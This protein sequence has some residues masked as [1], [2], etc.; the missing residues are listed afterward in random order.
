MAWGYA[1][2][3]VPVT[4]IIPPPC[5]HNKGQ[6]KKKKETRRTE[7]RKTEKKKQNSNIK[8][9]RKGKGTSGKEVPKSETVLLEGVRKDRSL[10]P[11]PVLLPHRIQVLHEIGSPFRRSDEFIDEVF[12][13][14]P[15]SVTSALPGV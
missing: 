4:S 14:S 7:N 8:T 10:G 3:G 15:F 1:P 13:Q 12:R 6:K 2:P 11:C 5:E 9:K